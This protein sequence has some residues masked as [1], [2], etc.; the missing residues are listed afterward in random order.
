MYHI[1]ITLDKNN[2]INGNYY[3]CILKDEGEISYNCGYGWSN[4]V[5]KAAFDAHN[6]FNKYILDND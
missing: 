1:E 6:Y 3:W 2:I 5:E 4:S